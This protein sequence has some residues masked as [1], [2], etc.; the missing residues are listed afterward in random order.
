MCREVAEW[1]RDP[2]AKPWPS[3]DHVVRLAAL[4]AERQ[5]PDP[6]HEH[7]RLKTTERLRK[8]I[9]AIDVLTAELPAMIASAESYHRASEAAGRP[10]WR[11]REETITPAQ[12]LLD[13]AINADGI[14]LVPRKSK[15]GRKRPWKSAATLAR[16]FAIAAW[17]DAGCTSHFSYD[18][19][20][21]LVH[22]IERALEKMNFTVQPE[23]ISKWLEEHSKETAVIHAKNKA[24]KNTIKESS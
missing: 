24:T 11:S 20:G 7:Q 8:V 1:F 9:A 3:P 16:M 19:N 12:A 4:C 17:R 14:F 5:Q 13:A 2:R 15:P 21:P 10:T 18:R 22:V 23:T 6:I